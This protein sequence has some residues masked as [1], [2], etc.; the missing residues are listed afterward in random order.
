MKYRFIR[1]LLNTL[2][3]IGSYLSIQ[4]SLA[5]NPNNPHKYFI[6][7]SAVLFSARFA[8]NPVSDID[9]AINFHANALV[10]HYPYV[11]ANF[12]N[13]TIYEAQSRLNPVEINAALPAFTRI[14]EHAC[15]DQN[16]NAIPHHSNPNIY[17]PDT[18][19]AGFRQEVES[20]LIQAQAAGVTSLQQ[21]DPA[22]MIVRQN[23]GCYSDLPTSALEWYV[24]DYYYWLKGRIASIFGHSVPMT[25]NMSLSNPPTY[26]RL[27][28]H[29]N[30]VMGEAQQED[31]TPENLFQAIH[32]ENNV[33]LNLTTISTLV[34][35][36]QLRNRR[37]IAS[38]YA[39][40][41]HPIIPYDVYISSG[42]RYYGTTSQY[43]PYYE[44]VQNNASI[45]SGF[46]ILDA[47]IDHYQ[48]TSGV[49][50]HMGNL[51]GV[52][53]R[54]NVMGVL[55]GNAAGNRVLHV[56]N[57]QLQRSGMTD[58]YHY[59][60]FWIDKSA[61]P[62]TPTSVRIHRP[63]RSTLIKPVHDN[64]DNRWKVTVSGVD[65]WAVAEFQ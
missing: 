40:G 14:P 10:W 51:S 61:I 38:V 36:S 41:G 63:G 29:F 31:N 6:P 37:H 34:D 1:L 3:F 57:W 4:V 46:G 20:F 26:V 47:Y 24:D 33:Q 25:Y 59:F 39:L 7:R 60:T 65:I 9:T 50:Q 18:L 19:S 21:D 17:Y 32:Q 28:K 12:D 52:P 53:S 30:A 16:G 27:S 8:Q 54:H 64:G 2:I 49:I 13:S 45:L 62:F 35:T 23:K 44:L 11:G 15:K 56:V 48:N 5:Q 42:T 43:A 55:K 22:F 58:G